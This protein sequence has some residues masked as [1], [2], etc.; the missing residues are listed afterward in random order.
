M[1]KGVNEPDRVF[2]PRTVAV[3]GDKRGTG[4]IMWL[5]SLGTFQGRGY[6]VQIDPNEP[7]GIEALGVENHFALQPAKRLAYCF[8]SS[9]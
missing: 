1:N 8:L 9:G 4:Y 6:S 7:A 5:R 3:V 2:N